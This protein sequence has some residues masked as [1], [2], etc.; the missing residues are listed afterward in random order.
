MEA[1]DWVQLG[2][3]VVLFVTMIVVF[4]YAAQ[5]RRH[6]QPVHVDAVANSV[7][8][9]RKK[10]TLAMRALAIG[11]AIVAFAIATVACDPGFEITF[12]NQTDHEIRVSVGEETD[13][14]A[15]DAVDMGK[16]RALTY[17]SRNPD[18]FRVVIVNEDGGTL[19][20]EIFTFE[21]LEARGMRFVIDNEGIQED[22]D[23]PP[24]PARSRR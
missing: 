23:V 5:T 16:T 17:L 22:S 6:R 12:E 3:L 11:L 20:D 4:W 2:I 13:Q 21:E 1:S 18:R 14:L 19:L 9:M 10:E 7:Q 15:F 8:L 24:P